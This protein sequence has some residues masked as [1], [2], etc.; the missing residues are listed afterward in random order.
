MAGGTITTGSIPR[1]VQEGLA[2]IFGQTYDNHPVE[3]DKIFDLNT[4]HKNFELDQQYEGFGLA[5]VKPE[6]QEIEFDS[7]QQGFTPQ[8]QHLTYAKGFIVT[9]EA[10]EDEL[11]GVFNKKAR[12]LAY[13][14]QQTKEIVG[15]DVLND[16]F[17]SATLMPGGDGVSLFNSDHPNGPSG[18]TYENLLTT[19][20][21]L[22]EKGIE[23]LVIQIKNATDPRG[24][25]IALQPERLVVPTALCFEAQRIL[26][27]VLQNDSAN[28]AVNALRDMNMIPGG[29]V[30]NH[31][32]DS[33]AAWFIKTNA[34]EGMKYWT[35]RTVSFAEDNDFTTYNMRMK[36]DER[37]SFGWSDAR[38]MYG[39]AG[40]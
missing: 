18:G 33:D 39:S 13:S 37:Y 4:S 31:Y 8:Y 28:N 6:G 34:P 12:A 7:A 25:K 32:L 38:G 2:K 40:P 1:L 30:V 14:M 23:T 21:D 27:S 17:S 20:T 9:Q 10:L 3:W 16:G 11:Y 15:A 36:A 29:Y 26:M 19:D 35:R 24:L 5:P 22:S